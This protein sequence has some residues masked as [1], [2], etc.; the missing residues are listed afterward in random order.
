MN[1]VEIIGFAAGSLGISLGIPQALQIRR[2]GHGEGVSRLAWVLIFAM[3]CAWASYGIRLGSPSTL[4]TNSLYALVT[5]SVVVTLIGN[6]KKSLPLLLVIL[7]IVGG[8]ILNLPTLLVSILL[9]AS[10]F[11][12]LPQVKQSLENLKQKKPSA[13]SL[14]T[15]YITAVSVTLWGTYGALHHYYLMILTSSI[16]L[17]MTLLIIRLEKRIISSL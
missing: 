9:T 16:A 7:F 2:L 3:N 8:L 5:A 13:V 12:Q 10:V 6:S 4:V 17:I 11:S 14:N 15:L 1:P